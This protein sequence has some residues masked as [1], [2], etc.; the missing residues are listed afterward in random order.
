MELFLNVVVVDIFMTLCCFPGLVAFG[1]FPNKHMKPIISIE[2]CP[3]LNSS[4][5]KLQKLQFST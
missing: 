4:N 3:Y 1:H 2:N 5:I